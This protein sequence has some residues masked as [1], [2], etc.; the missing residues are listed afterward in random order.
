MDG[1]GMSKVIHLSELTEIVTKIECASARQQQELTIDL[2]N[3]VAKHCG[4]YFAC[5]SDPLGGNENDSEYAAHFHHD[6]NVPEGG[7]VFADYDN[8]VSIE[9]WIR[10]SAEAA[11]PPRKKISLK[12]AI[13]LL[14]RAGGVIL[15]SDSAS[16]LIYPSIDKVDD[17]CDDETEFLYLGWEVDGVDFNAKFA[18]GDNK[19]V[20]VEGNS[21]YLFD[22]DS[23]NEDPCELT[24]LA[25]MDLS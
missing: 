16:P 15:K 3:V 23:D 5:I 17:D 6:G 4:G 21:M 12:R 25:P 11:T 2:A 18:V 20:M 10:E 22:L 13:E 14:E 19:E 9:E 1:F 7:G 8:D 24:F